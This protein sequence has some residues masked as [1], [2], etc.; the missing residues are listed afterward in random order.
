LLTTRVFL[1][2]DAYALVYLLREGAA[3]PYLPPGIDLVSIM[4]YSLGCIFIME[5]R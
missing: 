3:T 2:A 4:G 1:T 5:Y